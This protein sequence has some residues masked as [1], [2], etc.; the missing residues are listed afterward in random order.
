MRVGIL[1]AGGI[2]KSMAKTIAGLPDVENYA[3][4]SRELARAQAF[5][6]DWGFARAYGS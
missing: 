1:G 6:R 3:I 5:A 2:A 4:A